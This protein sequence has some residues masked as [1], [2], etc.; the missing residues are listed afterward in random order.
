MANA[1]KAKPVENVEALLAA[2]ETV[3]EINQ[4]QQAAPVEIDLEEQRKLAEDAELVPIIPRR[5]LGRS[6]IGGEWYTFVK[7]VEVFVPRAVAEHLFE[8]GV[9]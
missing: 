2:T 1:Q 9:L 6:R 4:V 3:E 5:N 8:K 7:N